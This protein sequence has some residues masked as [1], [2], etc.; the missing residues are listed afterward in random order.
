MKK[1]LYN[2]LDMCYTVVNMVYCLQHVI[3]VSVFLSVSHSVHLPV[4][5][6]TSSIF[7]YCSTPSR[8]LCAGF[9]STLTLTLK[10]PNKNLQQKT[11]I[12]FLSFE[13]NKS[14]FFH[15]NLL[16]SRGFTWNIKSYFLWKTMKKYLWISSAAVVIGALRV[17]SISCWSNGW[18]YTKH[19]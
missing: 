19:A 2:S 14:W 9:K 13:E 4:C 5:W 12:F 15:V 6:S 8:E 7:P 10:V 3:L 16:P 17:K 1:F 18:I 11:L